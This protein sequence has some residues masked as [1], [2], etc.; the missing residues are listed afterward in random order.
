MKK[1]R[2]QR[3]IL[4]MIIMSFVMGSDCF[5]QKTRINFGAKVGINALSTNY[6]EPY[7]EETPLPKGSYTNK[8]GYLLNAFIRIN[9]DNIFLQ[10]ELGWSRYRQNCFFTLP[11]DIATVNHVADERGFS[12][13]L[14]INS[15]SL[16]ANILA[17]YNVI[18]KAPYLFNFYVGTSFKGIYSR[19]YVENLSQTFSENEPLFDYTGILGI[20]MNISKLHFDMR[21]EFY[22]SD[23]VFILNKVPD[24]P[25]KYRGITLKKTE[26]ILSFSCG[27]MF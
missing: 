17:G 4:P 6:Y 21:Y 23:R 7:F 16:N 10:P 26:N 14:D 2:I 11:A 9:Y 15:N 12:T 3:F 20:S 1:S 8:N 5:A 27:I 18:R 22:Q 13:S 25:E 24:F 19:D